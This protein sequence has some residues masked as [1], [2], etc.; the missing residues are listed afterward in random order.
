MLAA[1]PARLGRW[2]KSILRIS[3]NHLL[4]LRSHLQCVANRR[5][6]G[7]LVDGGHD[8][9]P[10]ATRRQQIAVVH[11]HRHRLM[12]GQEPRDVTRDHGDLG[13][14][15]LSTFISDELYRSRSTRRKQLRA[16]FGYENNLFVEH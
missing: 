5:R 10:D 6:T 12:W 2:R 14:R 8:L 4:P 7:I 16:S 3:P 9:R 15:H 1:G 11:S 13:S